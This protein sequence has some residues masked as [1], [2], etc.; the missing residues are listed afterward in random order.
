MFSEVS[1]CSACDSVCCRSVKCKLLTDKGCS[2][3]SERPLFCNV[4]LYFETH[5]PCKTVEEW[6]DIN[7]KSCAS[8]QKAYKEGKI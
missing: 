1:N 2:I 7:L 8:L 3:Y 6:Y 5:K 4:D